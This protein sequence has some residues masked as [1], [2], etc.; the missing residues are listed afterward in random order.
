MHA[1][2]PHFAS[3]PANSTMWCGCSYLL[4]DTQRA[5]YA[6]KPV[7][8]I[9]HIHAASREN[10]WH[11]DFTRHRGLGVEEELLVLDSWWRMS[12]LDGLPSPHL[13]ASRT[14]EQIL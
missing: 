3:S 1:P 11:H 4:L 9:R 10:T 6:L 2:P 14:C 8:D 7:A 5:G 13:A 12:R